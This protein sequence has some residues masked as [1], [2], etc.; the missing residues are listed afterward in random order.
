MLDLL[1]AR[2]VLGHTNI[3][4]IEAVDTAAKKAAEVDTSALKELPASLRKGRR[5][6]RL[7]Q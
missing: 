6:R 5:A 7:P 3:S 2:R 1:T 4:E